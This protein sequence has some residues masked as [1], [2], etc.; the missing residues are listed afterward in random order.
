MASIHGFFFREGG[1]YDFY[2][3]V[4]ERVMRKCEEKGLRCEMNRNQNIYVR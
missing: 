1:D 2:R 4:F 3:L